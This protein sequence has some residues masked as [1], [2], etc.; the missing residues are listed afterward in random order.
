MPVNGNARRRSARYLRG[1][2]VAIGLG[3]WGA[4]DAYGDAKFWDDG[5]GIDDWWGRAENWNP[6]GVPTANSDVTLGIFVETNRFEARGSSFVAPL[7]TPHLVFVD[8]AYKANSLTI[9][10]TTLF[11][12]DGKL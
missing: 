3:A 6:D 9:A 8:P 1:A 7:P 2:A 4:A 12:V 5:G 10:T 11:E